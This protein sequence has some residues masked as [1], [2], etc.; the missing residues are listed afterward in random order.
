MV[1][2][3]I[4][5]KSAATLVAPGASNSRHRQRSVHTGRTIALTSKA[6]TQTKKRSGRSADQCS[7]S[8]DLLFRYPGN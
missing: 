7:Q 8:L 6:I 5:M 3:T 4:G 1:D 2:V